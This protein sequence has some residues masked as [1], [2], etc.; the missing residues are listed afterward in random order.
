MYMMLAKD[1]LLVKHM[2]KVSD[3]PL[4]CIHKV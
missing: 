1:H 2:H 4:L 3:I